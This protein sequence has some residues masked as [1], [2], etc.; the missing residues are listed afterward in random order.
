MK[1]ACSCF[2]LFISGLGEGLDNVLHSAV[3]YSTHLE[4]I[5]DLERW[6]GQRIVLKS[7]YF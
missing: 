3:A 1:R 2:L 4:L 6:P 5:S 7:H